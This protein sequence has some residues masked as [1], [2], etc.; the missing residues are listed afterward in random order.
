MVFFHLPS[1][2]EF[3][4]RR[5]KSRHRIVGMGWSKDEILICVHD[6]SMVV[7]YSIQGDVV[8][9]YEGAFDTDPTVAYVL[10][11]GEEYDDIRIVDCVVYGHG[12]SVLT[13]NGQL[14][15]VELRSRGGGS[16]GGAFEKAIQVAAPRAADLSAYFSGRRAA[17]CMTVLESEHQNAGNAKTFLA[18]IDK[19]VLSIDHVTGACRDLNVQKR[20]NAER[21]PILDMAVSPNGQFVACFQESGGLSVFSTNDFATLRSKFETDTDSLY[22]PVQMAW[23]GDDTIVL[24]WKKSESTAILLV[25]NAR[26]ECFSFDCEYPMHV[27]PEVDC[28]RFFA[29]GACRVLERVPRAVQDVEDWVMNH[30]AFRLVHA[31]KAFEIECCHNG[32]SKRATFNHEPLDDE[33][34]LCAKHKERDMIEVDTTELRELSSSRALGEAV[35]GCL[36]AAKL[37]YSLKAQKKYLRAAVYG[38]SRGQALI[39]FASHRQNGDS[40]DFLSDASFDDLRRRTERICCQLW[41]LNRVRRCAVGMPLTVRQLK[42][43]TIDGIRFRLLSRRYHRAYLAIGAQLDEI[44][45]SRGRP[46]VGLGANAGNEGANV[47]EHGRLMASTA[48]KAIVQWAFDNPTG[49]RG[50][51]RSV[52]DRMFALTNDP[53]RKLEAGMTSLSSSSEAE[54]QSGQKKRLFLLLAEELLNTTGHLHREQRMSIVRELL[55]F[56]PNVVKDVDAGTCI[57][58]IR[59]LLCAKDL[60]KALEVARGADPGLE[61]DL[62]FTILFNCEPCRLDYFKTVS[63]GAG[64][65]GEATALLQSFYKKKLQ[66][67]AGNVV[68]ALRRGAGRCPKRGHACGRQ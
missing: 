66:K 31:C 50:D 30:P 44:E 48:E 21:G 8:D 53:R 39:K 25:Y 15:M 5:I 45:N 64:A 55:A 68:R 46:A 29:G 62:N 34:L 12:I 3:A 36:E 43:L 57:C 61:T 28:C 32:C 42:S 6:D 40:G 16:G 35:K 23:C 67:R 10:L 38:I 60:E 26:M 22:P 58:R 41:V 1:G 65:A 4:H 27:I 11:P 49:M 37:E 52:V 7:A 33:P 56:G 24:V 18:T 51:E 19:T 13:S 9:I 2:K 17:L 59:L 47:G 54:D 14:L 20:L 63:A